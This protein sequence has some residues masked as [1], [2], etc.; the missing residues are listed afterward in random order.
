MTKILGL[1][2]DTTSDKFIFNFEDIFFTA[3]LSIYL[4]PNVIY[5]KLVLRFLIHWDLLYQSPYRLKFYYKD[6]WLEKYTWESKIRYNYIQKPMRY[7]NELTTLN[8]LQ[9]TVTFFVMIVALSI[10]MGFVIVLELFL[11]RYHVVMVFQWN[12][13][14]GRVSHH[15]WCVPR[16][17]L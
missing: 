17:E 15:L 2:W 1:N 11:Q 3:E 13:E 8:K 4:S 7:L 6:V 9:L 14:W 12:F 10:S 16:L 5:W